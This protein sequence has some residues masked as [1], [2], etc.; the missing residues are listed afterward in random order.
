MTDI[1]IRLAQP[2]DR[3]KLIELQRRASLASETGDVR[4]QLL[5]DPGIIDLD[6]EM[7]ANN[8][9]FVAEAGDRIVGFATI[10]AH[11]GNDA[12]LEG[13]FVEPT[14]WRKG[15]ATKLVEAIEREAAAWGASRL[16]VMANQNVIGFYNA[17]G[18][19]KIGERK[20]ELGPIG[21]LM[22]RPVRAQ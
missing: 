7:L 3:L 19:T 22:V 14:E 11:E 5:D 8:E 21:F 15:I 18:F 10:V 1:N 4:Q 13:L 17:T 20:T 2:D 16:H 6:E 12:E 9:V